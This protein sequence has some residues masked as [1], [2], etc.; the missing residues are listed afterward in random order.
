[1]EKN[2]SKWFEHVE[3]QNHEEIVSRRYHR[4]RKL[5]IGQIRSGWRLLVKGIIVCGAN[6]DTVR[7]R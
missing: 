6:E 1:M 7:E 3:R 2:R 4:Y 5:G